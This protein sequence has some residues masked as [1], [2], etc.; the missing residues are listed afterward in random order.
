MCETQPFQARH[1]AEIKAASAVA[2]VQSGVERTRVVVRARHGRVLP[3]A[4]DGGIG[5]RIRTPIEGAWVL[6][7]QGAGIGVHASLPA[8]TCRT[9]A[10]SAARR[11]AAAAAATGRRSRASAEVSRG[12]GMRPT[13][14]S[15]IGRPECPRDDSCE[16][17]APHDARRVCS[18]GIGRVGCALGGRGLR[19]VCHAVPENRGKAAA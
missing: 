13:E 18:A 4:T 6:A 7:W 19:L 9:C 15:A 17:E 11:A 10:C 12:L 14:A 8:C 16:D 2:C 5:C 3:G 1:L